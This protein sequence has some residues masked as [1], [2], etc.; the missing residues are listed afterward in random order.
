MEYT[1]LAAPVKSKK[2]EA[3]KNNSNA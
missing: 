1:G 2:E 3:K